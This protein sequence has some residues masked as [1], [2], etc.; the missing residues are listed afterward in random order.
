MN[1]NNMGGDV[2]DLRELFSLLISKL[3]III[4]A[5][6]I[7][8][9]LAFG[10][11][12]VFVAPTYQ[13]NILMYVNNSNLSIGSASFSI[14]NADLTAAQK[15]VN[16]Y[17][18]IL[19]S[20][21]VLNEVKEQAGVNYSYGQLKSMISTTSVDDTEVFK[22]V[23]TST[24]PKEAEKIANT[25]AVVLPAKISDIVNGS[26]VKI[27]DYAVVPAGRY[28]PNYMR[29]ASIGA[30]AGAVIAAFLICIVYIFDEVI[31][32]EDYLTTTYPDIPLLAVIPDLTQEGSGSYGYGS[33]APVKNVTPNG[34][35]NNG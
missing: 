11:T 31:H 1:D 9:G 17:M 26:D 23:V 15:L 16:T 34:G 7:V 4:F 28:A 22:V 10:Y 27:V 6:I 33:S 32:S 5:A 25:I 14:S 30:L 2:I 12:K 21:K 3:W 24:D 20:R 19:Q 29:N 18:V 35:A 8:G 13:A